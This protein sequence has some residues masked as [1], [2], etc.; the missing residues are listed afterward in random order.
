MLCSGPVPTPPKQ[1]RE[2]SK[3]PPV[4]KAEIQQ[5]HAIPPRPEPGVKQELARPEP[6]VAPPAPQAARGDHSPKLEVRHCATKFKH[7][8]IP[9]LF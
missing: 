4:V 2:D 6:R 3:D 8:F 1:T 5:A 9:L 7:T